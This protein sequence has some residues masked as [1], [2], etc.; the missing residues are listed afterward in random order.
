M[1]TNTK[2]TPHQVELEIK[3]IEHELHN[4]RARVGPVE[5]N[6]LLYE[7]CRLVPATDKDHMRY[8]QMRSMG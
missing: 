3:R 7:H 6:R 2:L 8:T 1:P 5:I 4:L